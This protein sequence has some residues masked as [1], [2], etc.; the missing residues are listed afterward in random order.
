MQDLKEQMLEFGNPAA[1]YENKLYHIF[2]KRG[3]QKLY[4]KNIYYGEANREFDDV[5]LEPR[6]KRLLKKIVRHQRNRSTLIKQHIDDCRTPGIWLDLGCGIGQFMNEILKKRQNYVIG[7]EVAL[8]Q[9]EIASAL[10]QEKNSAENFALVN[11]GPC[12][13]PFKEGKF[14]YILSA[15]VLEHVGYENQKTILGEILRVMKPGGVCIIHTPNQNRTR[16]TTVLKKIY[17]AARGFNPLRI[18]HHFP[19]DHSSLSSAKRLKNICDSIG[20]R[21]QVF[22]QS[23]N[24]FPSSC[25]CRLPGLRNLLA[26][27][28]ILQ[29]SKK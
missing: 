26:K 21:V 4:Y 13:L 11:Q 22:F 24:N 10:L 16:I 3:K 25:V 1:Y 14:D 2:C 7:S 6:L 23:T 12:E 9:L 5:R 19:L 15:D 8:S 20:A 29:I 27:S 28:F 18:K 17:Y